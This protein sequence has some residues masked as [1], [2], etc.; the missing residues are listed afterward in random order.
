MIEY[1][2]LHTSGRIYVTNTVHL[3][4]THCILAHPRPAP[5]TSVRSRTGPSESEAG[6]RVLPGGNQRFQA[7]LE[8]H[9]WCFLSLMMMMMMTTTMIMILVM[10]MIKS[11][12][13]IPQS[14]P[15]KHS[16][17]RFML[18]QAHASTTA[19]T[20]AKVQ[21]TRKMRITWMMGSIRTWRMELDMG[22]LWLSTW[23][24]LVSKR[25]LV[26]TIHFFKG[27]RNLTWLLLC[28]P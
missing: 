17:K 1:F 13:C 23:V 22:Y 14:C 19:E 12:S 7:Q 10:I 26:T 20:A 15:F 24:S 27:S 8:W 5:F 6:G 3:S 28:L 9:M 25:E 16:S 21:T 2:Q 4:Y 18:F 11:G